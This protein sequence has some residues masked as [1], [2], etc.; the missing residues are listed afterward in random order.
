M[1]NA[2]TWCD[3]VI[4]QAVANS[5][6]CVIHITESDLNKPGGTI[7]YPSSTTYHEES[8]HYL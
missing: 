8:K 2:G 1:S 3:N 7:I 6:N 4:I 5:N